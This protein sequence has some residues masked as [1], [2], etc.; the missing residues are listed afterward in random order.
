MEV[1]DLARAVLAGNLLVARQWVADALRGEID[2]AGLERPTG[3]SE[4]ELTVAAGVVEML[5]A[6]CGSAAPDWTS[7]VGANV[8]PLVLDPGLESMPRSLAH[9]QA[10]GPEALRRRNLYALPDFLDVR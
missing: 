3:L 1:V 6:R 7:G 8:A 9:A 4:R 2:W 10:N 5:A